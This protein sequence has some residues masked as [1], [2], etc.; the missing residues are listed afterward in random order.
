M[1]EYLTPKEVP[2]CSLD[3]LEPF[4]KLTEKEKLYAHY[5]DEASWAGAPI[6]VRQVST[7]SS[8]LIN[9]FVK[10]FRT[11]KI[12]DVKLAWELANSEEDV[13]N[14]LNYISCLFGNLGNYLSFGDKK[15]IP[16]V[17]RETFEKMLQSFDKYMHEDQNQSPLNVILD[18]AY[19]LKDNEKLLGYYP[20]GV[21]SYTS[22]N[23]TKEEVEKV[24]Q[25]LVS[26]G[27]ELWNTRLS[28]YKSLKGKQK[29]I[30]H[31]ASTETRTKELGE[32]EE[33]LSCEL[34][35]GDYGLEL[36]N[37]IN[38]LKEAR[39]YAAND[40]Q[41]AMLSQY[42]VHFKSGLIK[43]HKDAQKW[44]IKDIEPSVETNI[45]FIE[46]YRDP[47][48]V[49]SEFE[50]FVS[51]VDKETS[52]KFK[53]MVDMAPQLLEKLP[54]S[55]YFEKDEF[56]K[57]DFTS[58]EV[59]T[60]V[61]SGIPAGIN[62]PNYDDVRQNDGFKN[63]NLGN[64]VRAAYGGGAGSDSE[65]IEHLSEQDNVV[66][67]AN[68]INSFTIDVAGH[69]LLGHGSGKLFY[70]N[71]DGST[72]FDTNLI[73][74]LTGNQI[75]TCYLEGETYGSKFG[76]MGSSYEECKAECVGLLMSTVKEVHQIFGSTN[77]EDTMYTS[78]LWMVRAGLVSLSAYDPESKRWT[79]A[80]SQA[81]FVIYRVLSEVDG[82]VNV[83]L[84]DSKDDFTISLDRSK[85]L[86]SGLDRLN[87]FLLRLQVY[88]SIADLNSAKGIYE[89]FSN[90]DDHHVE[91]RKIVIGRKKPRHIFVQPTTYL[92][93]GSAKLKVYDSSPEGL[94][95]SF[96]T[97]YPKV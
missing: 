4:N 77:Y 75:K 5:M 42:I 72:N 52:A 35:Y 86:G 63:V 82:F 95:E 41:S 85:I 33:G 44:W 31:V 36:R 39:K 45:G 66:Y 6:V 13:S 40:N 68:I 57:P 1:E 17:D 23:M 60:F 96:T 50:S 89:F 88:K 21:T 34:V 12:T 22:P 94:I 78:W 71:K 76:Q 19:S 55:S 7:E 54:W 74:P 53:E 26:E 97:N 47:S 62:I 11:H 10:F 61:S 93:D 28:K 64:I 80:H 32:I 37:V 58:L 92:E 8:L 65:R 49:R 51:I 69:E 2:I 79:Q 84:N 15:F 9:Y 73:N 43:F 30:V 46:H 56:H 16:R 87:E 70:K 27:I 81:R 24:N 67:K 3:T 91:L 83:T 48:G 20:T 18:L 38:N 90:V 14:A 59:I 29:I 25:L